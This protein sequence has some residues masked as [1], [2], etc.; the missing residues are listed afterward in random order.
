MSKELTFIQLHRKAIIP[1]YQTD[2]ASGFDFH[3]YV[4][5]LDNNY[6]EQGFEWDPNS[7]KNELTLR[8]GQKALIRTA[9]QADIPDGY[10]I[11]VRPR[12]G[13]AAKNGITVL[14]APGTID[15]DYEGEIKVIL[16]NTSD[17][18]FIIRTGDRIAQGVF[19]PVSKAKIKKVSFEDKPEYKSKKKK[20]STR[21]SEGFG[22]TGVSQKEN[23]ES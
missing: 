16:Q 14:N 12:S 5:G 22:S 10:E 21:K 9:L 4:H 2:G 11:Q 19:V 6:L 17:Q 7:D 18:D 1:Q 15:S 20:K 8:A 13:I 3:A 23:D